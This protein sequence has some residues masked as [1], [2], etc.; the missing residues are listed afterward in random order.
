ME[1]DRSVIFSGQP[2]RLSFFSAPRLFGVV[3]FSG[4]FFTSFLI[5]TVL[6]LHFL[7]FPF[8]L[9]FCFTWNVPFFSSSFSVS[10]ISVSGFF[11]SLSTPCL[12]GLFASS[13]FCFPY[14]YYRRFSRRAEH[15]YISFSVDPPIRGVYAIMCEKHDTRKANRAIRA[16]T[17]RCIE[18]DF[19][20]SAIKLQR[21]QKFADNGQRTA[22]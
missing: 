19:T 4:V 18:L 15:C 5:V 10:V 6:K 2:C 17:S 20:R 7:F 11:L 8:R 22:A 9:F 16:C 12:G 14:L 1:L 3:L 13:F 21:V